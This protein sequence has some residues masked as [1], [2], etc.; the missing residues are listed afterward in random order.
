M[1]NIRYIVW[2]EKRWPQDKFAFLNSVQSKD[3][4]PLKEWKHKD[5]GRIILYRVLYQKNG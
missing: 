5:T 1:R 2:E 3:L 4:T